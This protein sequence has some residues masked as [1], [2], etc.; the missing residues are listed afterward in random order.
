MGVSKTGVELA[1]KFYAAARAV[2][3]GK[4]AGV[5]EAAFDVKAILEA[6][7]AGAG[8]VKGSKLAGVKWRGVVF[9]I[10]GTTNPVALVRAA[11]PAHLHNNPTAPHFIGAKLLGTRG[12]LKG[13]SRRVGATAAFGGSNRGAFGA[14]R[15]LKRGSR[16]LVIPGVESPRAYA[17]HP[18]TSGK[19]WWQR[20]MRRVPKA[21]VEAYR[22][23]FRRGIRKAL[24]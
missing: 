2:D 16:A 11:G 17:F 14:A 13:K 22:A 1:A 6:S 3:A 19:G 8:L 20:G 23:G 21:A 18:G 24:S 4:K 7:A 9:D 10:K 12:S 15:E 5:T